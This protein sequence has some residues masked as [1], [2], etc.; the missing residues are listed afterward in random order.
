MADGFFF[1]FPSIRYKIPYHARNVLCD[2]FCGGKIWF[3]VFFVA[4]FQRQLGKV[5]DLKFV[6][7]CSQPE[8]ER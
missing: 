6:S 5:F 3:G 8:E 1:P 7:V 2:F 4:I